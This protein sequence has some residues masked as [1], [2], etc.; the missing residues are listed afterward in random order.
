MTIIEVT[1]SK[2]IQKFHK[3][4]FQIY[5]E[6][7]NWIPHIQQEVE[8]IFNPKE[9][10][11][12]RHGEI[13]RWILQNNEGKTIGR[14][15]A[16]VNRKKAFSENQPTGGC[17]FFECIN[18]QKAANLLFETAKEWLEEREMEA[19]DGPINFGERD[20]YWGLVVEGHNNPPIY[21]NAY[22][23][24]YYK[25]L[26]ENYGFQLYFK[27]F[28][29]ERS[30]NDEIQEKYRKRSDI[31]LQNPD[32]TFKH[33][34]KDKMF[35]YA[36]D[37]RTVYNKAW[38]TH[39]NF[40]GM[41]ETQARSIIRKLKPVMDPQLIWFAYYQ[42]EAVGFFISLPELNQI[43][44]YINGHLNWWGKLKFLY[45]QKRGVCNNVFGLA[46]GIAPE[47]QKKGLEGA[48]IT[49]VKN[50]FESTN[51]K[52]QKIIIT[53]IGDFNPK[54]IRIVENLGTSKYMT[55]HTYRKL[56]DENAPFERCKTIH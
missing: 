17:G 18:D 50:Q 46:F 45:H 11:F 51:K 31:I 39:S 54:M 12:H 28:M 44:K 56:F 21:G 52:Y 29:Y 38:A 22:Q 26:F 8:S 7:E 48:I 19:M 40:K 34:E 5:K 16:F 47:H 30:V 35:E 41:S 23:P 32:Y 2:I 13:T 14:I 9:N 4:P 43:F 36:E 33:L 42:N 20:R 10:K 49:R 53:W 15:A 24:H 55:L 6:D 37:F 25:D 1:S 3:L 27:Q